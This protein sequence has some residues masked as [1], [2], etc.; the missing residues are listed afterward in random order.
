MGI[1]TTL[2]TLLLAIVLA[3]ALVVGVHV[4]VPEGRAP[5]GS[6]AEGAVPAAPGG[7]R[8]DRRPAALPARPNVVVVMADDMRHDD[9]R[10]AP[11]LR[12]LVARD[13]LTFRNAFSNYPLCCPARAS[14]LTGRLA[15]NHRV[16][17]HERPWGYG[18]FD[19]SRTLATALRRQGYR[20]GFVGKYLNGYGV[21]DSRVSGGPSYRYVP[22]GWDEWHAAIENPGRDGIHGGTY[23]YFDTPY[24]RNGR[25]DNRY[26]GRYQTDVIGDLSLDTLRRVSGRAPF[27]LNVNYVAPHHGAPAEPDDPRGVRDRDGR[28]LGLV[29]PARPGWVKGR[30][31][32]LVT[33]SPGRPR[34]GPAERDMS[35]KPP[36]IRS[37]PEPTAREWAAIREVARQ[38]AES[39]HVMDRQVGRL[40]RALKQRGEWSDT[41]L[42]FTS[43]NGYLL[44]EHRL[45]Q[46]KVWPHDPSLRVP[47]VVTGPGFRSGGSRYDPVST[48]DLAATVLDLA[49]ARMPWALDGTS[50]VPSLERDRGWT[51]PVP[52]EAVRT[53][54]LRP[55][56]GFSGPR[57]TIGVRTSRYAYFRHRVGADELYDLARDPFQL[58]SVTG[59]PR[60]ADERRALRRVWDATRNCRGGAC[61][62][63]LPALLRATAAG[64]RTRGTSY[65]RRLQ[66]V[67][68]YR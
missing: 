35:D 58:R 15:H 20:T 51:Q 7:A 50:R 53:S 56:Q 24:N 45:R 68:G 62:A 60:Y 67:Y 27:F 61:R 3:I 25:I 16:L 34:S 12:R 59:D 57:T 46:G 64:N 52:T 41:V 55:K 8:P 5:A 2:S 6:T 63:E 33:R 48:V 49:G 11:T 65:Q 14:F 9:L 1:R 66:R 4:L 28:L 19:D 22:R 43:D 13:G 23:D 17:S 37:R 21:M 26:R 42:A 31:D 54:R 29:T 39:I 18:S 32:R 30:F 10:F 47:L 36:A 40:V 38:R 44:G